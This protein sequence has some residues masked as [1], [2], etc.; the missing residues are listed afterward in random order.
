MNN[1][2][3]N[4]SKLNHEDSY[5][6]IYPQKEH[7]AENIL[8]ERE[9][10]LERLTRNQKTAP[11]NMLMELSAQQLTALEPLESS[12]ILIHSP[13]GESMPPPPVKALV[14]WVRRKND[15]FY[16]N[17]L[18]NGLPNAAYTR[19]ALDKLSAEITAVCQ[20]DKTVAAAL[21]NEDEQY[22]IKRIVAQARAG[23]DNKR[24]GAYIRNIEM[25]HFFKTKPYADER[26]VMARINGP[27][28][29]RSAFSRFVNEFR[30]NHRTRLAAAQ[31]ALEEPAGSALWDY[32][33]FTPLTITTGRVNLAQAKEI[34]TPE[35]TDLNHDDI[36]ILLKKH[37]A[38]VY[39]SAGQ[40][41][42][43]LVRDKKL[44]T[45]A[46]AAAA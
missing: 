22:F 38:L 39:K 2:Y 42:R 13:A 11:A 43:V 34:T 3:Y 32:S 41:T 1:F 24:L 27:L 26:E 18:L 40:I 44:I 36:K 7:V 4:A 9:C 29:E 37:P 31:E 35:C 6:N 20:E 28:A 45:E 30:Q 10:F 21:L 15:E 16:T 12:S 33:Y 23:L 5:I 25:G 8:D 17:I 14:A 19:C 46:L